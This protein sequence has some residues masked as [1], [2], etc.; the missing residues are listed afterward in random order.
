MKDTD[1]KILHELYQNKSI[2]K[3]AGIMYMTQP[4]ITKRIK[5]IEAEF[6]TKIIDRTPHGIDFT[7]TGTFLAGQAEKYIELQ[8]ESETAFVNTQRL[9]NDW[10]EERFHTELPKCNCTGYMD[11]AWRMIAKQ[12]GYTLSF[13][14][15]EYINEYH[16][17]L[18]PLMKKDGTRVVRNTWFVYPKEK[19]V[20]DEMKR[21]IDYMQKYHCLK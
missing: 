1:W 14:P 7:E 5:Q 6:Q 2:T 13:L 15:A 16:L 3:V 10:W 12:G 11:F 20:T 4:S 19:A 21:F 18:T 17:C 9:L 8:R